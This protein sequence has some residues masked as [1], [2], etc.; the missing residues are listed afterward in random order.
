MKSHE[1][2]VVQVRLNWAK[3]TFRGRLLSANYVFYHALYYNNFECC[4]FPQMYLAYYELSVHNMSDGVVVTPNSC[5][6]RAYNL[7]HRSDV[8]VLMEVNFTFF[9]RLP[10]FIHSFIHSLIYSFIHSFVIPFVIS[11]ILY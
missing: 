7:V 11:T 9:E 1:R 3:K 8:Q 5:H 10:L 2:T 4:K 6:V